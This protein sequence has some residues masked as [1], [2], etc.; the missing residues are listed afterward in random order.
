[1]NT[2]AS[3]WSDS[4]T[5]KIAEMRKRLKPTIDKLPYYPDVIGDRRLLRFLRGRNMDVTQA[6]ALYDKFMAFRKQYNVDEIRYNILFGGMNTAQKFPNGEKLLKHVPQIVA[7]GRAL[8]KQGNPVSFESYDFSPKVVLQHITM[9]EYILFL[10][11]TLEFKNLQ[12]E[13]LCERREA[14]TAKRHNGN[15]PV[16]YGVML[17]NC[18]V[19]DCKGVGM[20]HV[21]KDGQKIVKSALDLALTNYP[22][23]L[24]RS[25]MVNVPWVFSIIWIVVKQI[26]DANV[27]S[28]IVMC[29][30]DYMKDLL[31][32]MDIKSIPAAVGGQF[33][34]GNEPYDFE[35][36]I[37][38]YEEMYQEH[39]NKNELNPTAR[40]GP[41]DNVYVKKQ[42][43]AG[44]AVLQ[45]VNTTL[46]PFAEQEKASN[47]T[48]LSA[49]V[50]RNRSSSFGTT[51]TTAVIESLPVA[52]HESTIPVANE[53]MQELTVVD[54]QT[55][56]KNKCTFTF[57]KWWNED[58]MLGCSPK[59]VAFLLL[60]SLVLLATLYPVVCADYLSVLTGNS[61]ANEIVRHVSMIG[62]AC[63]VCT[64][65]DKAL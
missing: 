48:A 17:S 21:G 37:K 65:I 63:I 56:L 8:D 33:D 35:F 32:D 60:A 4:D 11:Y 57:T 61:M 3:K 9:E 53:I 26:L 58:S 45:P 27:I 30:N 38:R 44:G 34:G 36:I 51:T 10:I 22:E 59:V 18:I 49:L 5:A 50:S 29:G 16:G 28:K 31:N 20:E 12:L 7:S 52:S 62:S 13:D 24:A 14:E 43:L 23:M 39:C 40:I 2:T 41:S 46:K 54:S 47:A 1:M 64:V 15:P 6:C 25:Q 55:S 19:R 42:Q